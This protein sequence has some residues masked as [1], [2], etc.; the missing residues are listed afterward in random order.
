MI[1][2]S[3]ESLTGPTYSQTALNTK[4]IAAA[5]LFL[6]YI[7]VN[8]NA[9]GPETF[10]PTQPGSSRNTDNDSTDQQMEIFPQ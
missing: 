2:N 7:T 6:C 1:S 8:L 10:G 4:A 9:A 3:N 5:F